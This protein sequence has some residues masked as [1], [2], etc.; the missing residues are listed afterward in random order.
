MILQF[1][2]ILFFPIVDFN[3]LLLYNLFHF[4]P[5]CLALTNTLFQSSL[6]VPFFP[7]PAIQASSS[8]NLASHPIPH[9]LFP[10]A[11][12]WSPLPSNAILT[13]WLMNK[14][15][16]FSRFLGPSKKVTLK[17]TGE[18]RSLRSKTRTWHDKN[19]SQLWFW[20]IILFNHMIDL[21]QLGFWETLSWKAVWRRYLWNIS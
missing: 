11:I 17:H 10:W 4:H 8:F 14:L 6:P 13:S 7:Q 15:E 3:F 9:T 18:K 12:P 2:F 19:R 21:L 5:Q 1:L 16:S 20:S